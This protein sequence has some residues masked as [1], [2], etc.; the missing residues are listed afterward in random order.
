MLTKGWSLEPYFSSV[1]AASAGILSF[2]A[3]LGVCG[4]MRGGDEGGCAPWDGV[5]GWHSDG[6]SSTFL[7]QA[8]FLG[9]DV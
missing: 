2:D 7:F 6:V 5:T 8:V 1:F 3:T 9:L 4:V